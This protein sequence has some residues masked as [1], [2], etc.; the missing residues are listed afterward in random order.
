MFIQDP[1]DEWVCSDEHQQSLGE[2][3]IFT[4]VPMPLLLFWEDKF[5]K[6][7]TSDNGMKLK[8]ALMDFVF[9]PKWGD[10]EDNMDYRTLSF[11]KKNE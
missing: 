7:W 8:F 1:L 5:Y 9:L 4:Y 6:F 10:V 3:L 2:I 11:C